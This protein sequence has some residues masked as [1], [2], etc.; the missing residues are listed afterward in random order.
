MECLQRKL[1]FL[2]LGIVTDIPCGGL[3]SEK[4][5]DRAYFL[6]NFLPPSRIP[7]TRYYALKKCIVSNLVIYNKQLQ[8]R[9]GQWCLGERR[10]EDLK[11]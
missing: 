1:L 4:I 7:V 11:N 5:E 10:V 9:G 6:Q 3:D 8:K 2:Y